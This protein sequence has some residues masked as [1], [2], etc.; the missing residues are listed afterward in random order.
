MY[1]A[2]STYFKER[3]NIIGIA[4]P[5]LG[6]VELLIG[7]EVLGLHPVK[8]ENSGNLRILISYFGSGYILAGSH[9]SLAASDTNISKDYNGAN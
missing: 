9:P 5:P 4:S 6:N 7:S 8:F 2:S 1:P 3:S